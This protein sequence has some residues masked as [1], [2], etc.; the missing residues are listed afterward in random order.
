MS[1]SYHKEIGVYCRVSTDEQAQ[2]IEGSIKNQ[3]AAI[4]N[5]VK[6]ENINNDKWGEITEVY[7]DEG[8]SAKNLKRP[9]IKR[10][11]EDIKNNK[12]NTVII[13]EI[14]RL[15]RSSRDWLY[16]NSIFEKYNIVLI[17]LRQKFDTSQAAGRL[18]MAFMIEIAQFERE[19]VVER[20]KLSVQ[21]RMNRGLY[22]G[23]P[24]PYGFERTDKAGHLKINEGQKAIAIEIFNIFINKSGYLSEAI[25]LINKLEYSR[26]NGKAWTKSSLYRWIKNRALI[27]EIEINRKKIDKVQERL[28]PNDRYKVVPASW[29]PLVDKE[30]WEQA[31]QILK[32]N[33]RKLKVSTWKHGEFLLSGI[34]ECPLGTSLSGASGYGK[35]GKKHSQYRHGKKCTC[36]FHSL[37]VD[38]INEAVFGEVKRLVM[39]PQLLEELVLKVNEDVKAS[40]PDLRA[41]LSAVKV[42]YDAVAN[43]LGRITDEILFCEDENQKIMWQEKASQLQS[44]KKQLELELRALEGSKG[45]RNAQTFDIEGIIPIMEKFKKGFNDLPLATKSHLIKSIVHKVI[46]QKDKL[47]IY[48]KGPDYLANGLNERG[49]KRDFVSS[50]IC[51]SGE[52]NNDYCGKWG[53]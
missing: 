36:H 11:L 32:N 16:L 9:E 39:H 3:K 34:I 30:L 31:N 8:F 18:Q 14:S 40:Q 20:T 1:L 13:T 6:S 44:T 22:Q 26:S 41:G 4:M 2:V 49:V 33:Y 47:E 38:K 37:P 12:I 43:K 29:E 7:S 46:V 25:R 5:Y 52:Q 15:S 27:G 50:T 10:L 51:D 28:N 19:Q 45:T 23:G 21:A 53:G 17:C 42:K 24:I 48:L 35:S